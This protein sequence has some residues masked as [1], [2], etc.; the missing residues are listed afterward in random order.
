M[1][2]R[3]AAPTVD[4][5]ITKRRATVSSDDDYEESDMAST[6]EGKEKKGKKMTGRQVDIM[7]AKLWKQVLE[8]KQRYMFPT[9]QQKVEDMAAGAALSSKYKKNHS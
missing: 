5:G 3:K 9:E 1:K 6:N 7:N 2:K 8:A 4:E